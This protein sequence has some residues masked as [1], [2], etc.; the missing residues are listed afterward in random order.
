MLNY[1]RLT[2]SSFA[3]QADAPLGCSETSTAKK[4]LGFRAWTQ[5][6]LAGPPCSF[7]AQAEPEKSKSLLT[8]RWSSAGFWEN[9][10]PT[11]SQHFPAG[12]KSMASSKRTSESAY[13][14]LLRLHSIHFQKCWV[15]TRY[16]IGPRMQ[17]GRGIGLVVDSFQ[18]IILAPSRPSMLRVLCNLEN[19]YRSHWFAIG[20]A[21]RHDQQVTQMS[22]RMSLHH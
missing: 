10:I 8:S 12:H 14:C 9:R 19:P 20:S 7:P 2:S 16:T 11:N 3:C 15:L 13:V 6:F 1:Q 22:H 4:S 5:Q 21:S 18:D 17:R